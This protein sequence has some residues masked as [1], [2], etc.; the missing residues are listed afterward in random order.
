MRFED[1]CAFI[2]GTEKSLLNDP[3]KLW[4]FID[5]KSVSG[6]MTNGNG[7]SISARYSECFCASFREGVSHIE[8]MWTVHLLVVAAMVWGG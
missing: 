6:S 5:R 4:Q 3:K 2:I 7:S 1:N 8:V